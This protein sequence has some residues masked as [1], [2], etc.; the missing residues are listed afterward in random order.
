MARTAMSVQDAL[1]LT[2]DRPN[3]LMVIDTVMWFRAVPDWDEVEAVV[4]QR[5]V[6]R[7]PVFARHPVQDGST[8]YWEDDPDFDLSHHLVRCTVPDPGDV[9]ALQAYV[10]AQRSIPFDKS[11]PLWVLHLIDGVHFPTG[12]VGAAVMGRFHHAIADGVRLVQVTLGL[13]DMAED[14]VPKK[15]GK[16][17]RRSTTPA[18]I[19]VSTAKNVGRGVADVAVSSAESVTD[20]VGGAVGG[21]V[22]T[23]QAAL[24]G[25]VLGTAAKVAES[26][27][28]IFRSG[29]SVLRNPER[30][31]DLAK[32]VSSP[33]N[34]VVNDL[35]SVGKLALAGSSVDTVWTGTPGIAKGAYFAPMLDL[36]EVKAVRRA[37]GTTVNDVLLAAISG[38]LTR[39]L[40]EHGDDSVDEVL[41]MIPVSIKAFDAELPQDLGN[42][43][44]LVAFRMPLGIDDRR[45]RLAE[46]HER[47]ER[48]KNSDE[49]LL[50]FG[51]QRTISQ[52]PDGL[53]TFLTNFFANKAVGVLT[54]VPGPRRPMTL[55]GVEVDG[56][57][58]WAPCSGDQPMTICIFS[59]NGKV[60]IG[61]GVDTTLVPDGERLGVLLGEE[62]AQMH[63]EF[64]V[65]VP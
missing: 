52:A 3:S 40:R 18:A 6:E 63:D 23:V 27:S 38:A 46:V 53:A 5:L 34:R 24:S 42:Y 59:Y 2:M 17:L 56:V 30:V 45:A 26:G 65:P 31:A 51:V 7:F 20:V 4:Q 10:S 39:Y 1:W 29:L 50:T 41:W 11:R 43:F 13:C 49:A 58:G 64:V 32:V 28:N 22:G 37:T 19:A 62:F 60:A 61:F 48:I 21:T 16:K 44:A 33:G 25:D 47:M 55:A 9:A 54:N 14:A 8:W 57:L 35:A 12:D 36:G 15:V